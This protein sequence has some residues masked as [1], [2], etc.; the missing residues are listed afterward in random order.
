MIRDLSTS[1]DQRHIVESDTLTTLLVVVQRNRIEDWYKCYEKLVPLSN[2]E[3]QREGFCVLPKSSQIVLSDN[4]E[5]LLNVVLFKKYIDQ[6]KKEVLGHKF[7]VREFKFEKGSADAKEK[8]VDEL[9][10]K[11]AK[12]KVRLETILANFS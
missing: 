11:R 1:I 12:L 5:V 6:Y 9:K 8:R 2:N 4:E 7:Q 10:E 3:E